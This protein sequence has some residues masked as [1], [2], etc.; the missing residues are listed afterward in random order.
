MSPLDLDNAIRLAERLNARV[1]EEP[2][3]ENLGFS[4]IRIYED[5]GYKFAE[6][7]LGGNDAKYAQLVGTVLEH[8][9][10][11][12]PIEEWDESEHSPYP[13]WGPMP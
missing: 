2:H 3:V 1:S 10:F 13:T 11:F 8:D 6:I 12:M 9:H 7:T 5:N 4:T